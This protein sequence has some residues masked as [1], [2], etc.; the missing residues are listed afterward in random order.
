MIGE[1][2]RKERVGRS[3]SLPELARKT[4]ALSKERK[5]VD[6]IDRSVIHRIEKGTTLNPHEGT[7]RSIAIALDLSPDH[8]L[9]NHH[10]AADALKIAAPHAVFAAPAIAAALV[11]GIE[12]AE[13]ITFG[14]DDAGV[15]EP[16]RSDLSSNG[17]R[18]IY[19]PVPLTDQGAD[20]GR[21]VE[22]FGIR[23]WFENEEWKKLLSPDA[24]ARDTEDGSDAANGG[25]SDSSA[26]SPDDIMAKAMKRQRFASGLE[27]MQLWDDG[28]IDVAVIAA[29]V[30]FDKFGR[31]SSADAIH[32]CS[33]TKTTVRGVDLV[34][35]DHTPFREN[36]SDNAVLQKWLGADSG[37]DGSERRQ[38]KA[39]EVLVP[40][41]TLA[42]VQV[43]QITKSSPERWMRTI[44][45]PIGHFDDFFATLKKLAG[46]NSGKILAAIWQPYTAAL[47][48]KWEESISGE[49]RA[50]ADG[51]RHSKRWEMSKAMDDFG[52]VGL[53]DVSMDIIVRKSHL[54]KEGG[55]WDLFDQFLDKINISSRNMQRDIAECM[56]L[57]TDD[58]RRRH[59]ASDEIKRLARYLCISEAEALK[60]VA[61]MNFD[62][63]YT[64]AYVEFLRSRF[65]K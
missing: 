36:D 20:L 8:F 41:D 62:L 18:R 6:P 54:E 43:R 22:R 25:S 4:A 27:L 1:S 23:D 13:F 65:D 61:Q 24:D 30:F 17:H 42:A 19:R 35:F 21:G 46:G 40:S 9:S 44:E 28:D 37:D 48:R 64:P 60:A 63:S 16:K 3:L 56:S 11:T 51:F 2:V 14:T 39:I 12:K 38:D 52:T 55:N 15:F 58:L 47:R 5:D 7:L 31:G 34:A 32:A 59:E 33:L 10:I 49:G 45:H 29:D 53:R 26:T 57:G 50:V